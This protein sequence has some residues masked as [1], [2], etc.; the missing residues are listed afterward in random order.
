MPLVIVS[1]VTYVTAKSLNRIVIFVAWFKKFEPD[2][3]KLTGDIFLP[4][5]QKYDHSG[6]LCQN[7]NRSPENFPMTI[8][9]GISHRPKK[10]PHRNVVPS[11]LSGILW[12]V[13]W[14]GKMVM[15]WL[16]HYKN[17]LGCKIAATEARLKIQ[18]VKF[19]TVRQILFYWS[20]WPF[21]NFG[22]LHLQRLKFRFKTLET[23][24]IV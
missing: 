10:F 13:I 14:W 3:A 11:L 4:I 8:K 21:S 20:I 23:F 18:A 22:T 6:L 9:A 12:H 16:R 17:S 19:R 24:S 5:Q 1:H 7:E 2:E 15:R